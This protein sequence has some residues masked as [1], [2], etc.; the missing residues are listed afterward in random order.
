MKYLN[1]APKNPNTPIYKQFFILILSSY[2]LILSKKKLQITL[3]V[4]VISNK[5]LEGELHHL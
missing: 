1:I 2:I 4:G 5:A 3:P